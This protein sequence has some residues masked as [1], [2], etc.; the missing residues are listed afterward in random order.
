MTQRSIDEY[1]LPL[2]RIRHEHLTGRPRNGT[3]YLHTDLP[4]S[5][6]GYVRLERHRYAIQRTLD[7]Y[8]TDSI[9]RTHNDKPYY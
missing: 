1:I 6:L 5:I 3:L 8:L 9:A 4:P 2:G 7:D